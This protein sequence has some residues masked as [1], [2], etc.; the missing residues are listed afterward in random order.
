MTIFV[1]QFGLQR[2]GTN[3]VKGLLEANFDC[4]VFSN[5]PLHKHTPL[6][7]PLAIKPAS[8]YNLAALAIDQALYDAFVAAHAAQRVLIVCSL[9]PAG[10]WVEAYYRFSLTLPGAAGLQ[11]DRDFLVSALARW[12]DF[13]SSYLIF[14]QANPS[15]TQLVHHDDLLAGSADWLQRFAARS[16]LTPRAPLISA[17]DGYAR[18]GTDRLRG[19]E[20]I[21]ERQVFDRRSRQGRAWVA[22]VPSW[23]VDFI[24]AWSADLA[25]NLPEMA[26]Y[27]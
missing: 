6:R 24:D 25:A 21:D 18:R 15:V 8:A 20:V 10:S 17:L 4:R 3:I 11:F 5:F 7:A 23:A 22:R 16:G 19:R 14:A 26:A 13:N 12:R 27:V 1:K 9:R 2:S